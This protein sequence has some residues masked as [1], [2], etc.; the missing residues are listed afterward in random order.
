MKCLMRLSITVLLFTPLFVIGGFVVVSS[1]ALNELGP[2]QGAE[3]TRK[4]GPPSEEQ[5]LVEANIEAAIEMAARAVSFPV[6]SPAAAQTW[7]ALFGG[8]AV[9]GVIWS[10]S[11]GLVWGGLSGGVKM[12]M[13]LAGRSETIL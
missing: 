7:A 6:P 10:V 11:L 2:L 9:N 4:G 12:V 3:V 1:H 13:N 5:R 8:L